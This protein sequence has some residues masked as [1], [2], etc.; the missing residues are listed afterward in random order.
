MQGTEIRCTLW[1]EAVAKYGSEMEKGKAYYISKGRLKPANQ[2]YSTLA[3]AYELHFSAEYVSYIPARFPV[4]MRL[5]Y[6]QTCPQCALKACHANTLT[7]SSSCYPISD[8]THT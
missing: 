4:F 2:K 1:H 8:S 5:T 3:N 6:S 7:M